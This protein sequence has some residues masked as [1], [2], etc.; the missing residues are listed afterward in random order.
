[1]RQ[2]TQA[3]VPE[4][5][6]LVGDDV[7]GVKALQSRWRFPCAVTVRQNAELPQNPV[8]DIVAELL[9][10]VVDS[11]FEQTDSGARNRLVKFTA[12]GGC[13]RTGDTAFGRQ[14][15]LVCPALNHDDEVLHARA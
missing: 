7:G 2:G 8:A 14:G 15:G 4:E 12:R 11:I 3:I 6:H 5:H 10:I 13:K 9:V 1:M